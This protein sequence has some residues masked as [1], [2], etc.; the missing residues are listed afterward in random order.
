MSRFAVSLIVAVAMMAL[1]PPVISADAPQTSEAGSVV[2]GTVVDTSGKPVP[3]VE[4]TVSVYS[5][6]KSKSETVVTDKA[7]KFRSKLTLDS[8]NPYAWVS[9]EAKGYSCVRQYVHPMGGEDVTVTLRPGYTVRGKVV[10]ENGKLLA[11][12]KV[13]LSRCYAYGNGPSVDTALSEK[14]RTVTTGKDGCFSFSRL[15]SPDDFEYIDGQISVSAPGRALV[16]KSFRKETMSDIIK[17]C[18]PPECKLSGTLYLPEKSGFAPEKTRIRIQVPTDTGSE[19]RDAEVGKDGKFVFAQLPPGKVNVMLEAQ[20]YGPK[21]TEPAAWAMPAMKDVA[22]SPKQPRVIELVMVP[23]VLVQG[24]V[25]DQ[26]TGKGLGPARLNITHPGKPEGM[27]P[28]YASTDEN[29]EFSVR[30]VPGE[31]TIKVDAIEAKQGYIGF[32]YNERPSTTLTLKEGEDK[33]DVAIKVDPT[34]RGMGEWAVRDKPIPPDFELTPGT[35]DLT[36]DPE[37]ECAQTIFAQPKY[38]DDTVGNRIKKLPKL[39]SKRAKRLA[40]QF[41]G[42]GDDGLLLMAI[43]ESKGTKKGWDTAYVDLNRNGDLTDD[44]KVEIKQDKGANWARADWFTVQAH[45]GAGSARTNHPVQARL[46]LYGGAS[47]PYY[48][49][50]ERRG[51][52]KGTVD[53]SKGKLECV[54]IDATSNGI[55]GDF[56]KISDKLDPESQGDYVFV[57]TNGFGKLITTTWSPHCIPLQKI[58]KVG[59]KFYSIEMSPLGDKLTIAPYSGKYGRLTVRGENIEGLKAKAESLMVICESGYYSFEKCDGRPTTLPA[60]KYRVYSCDMILNT[61]N[62]LNLTCAPDSPVVLDPDKESVL[63]VSGKLSLAIESARKELVLLPGQRQTIGWDIKVG[64]KTTVSALGDS[65]RS[66]APKV[67]FYKNGKLLRTTTAE[68]G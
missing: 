27:F 28:D 48:M 50:L 64:D 40:Y 53:T 29:G 62:K 51:G 16:H 22:L 32:P 5:E 49:P 14:F 61:A 2:S 33:T 12:A 30:V 47:D 41:D 20:P 9:T 54:A 65:D 19:S 4:I 42:T 23:G 15:P 36:W 58:T 39:I 26:T 34:Q 24:A 37:I 18:D 60:G 44:T 21:R 63:T 45:Q 11:G 66:N 38:Q 17:I 35:Y 55:C 25:R 43:D 6:G 57:D 8:K 67:K 1:A 10:D 7:G 3:R 31:V 13:S 68:Y 59:D 46:M 56:V 52:W